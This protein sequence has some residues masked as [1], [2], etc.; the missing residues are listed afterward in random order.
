[1][2]EDINFKLE[3]PLGLLIGLGFVVLNAYFGYVIGIPLLAFSSD[4]ERYIVQDAVAPF[5]EEIVFRSFLPF[6]LAVLGIPLLINGI[7]NVVAFPIF[8]YVAY[9]A[10]FAAA[11]SLFIGAGI[12]ALAAF[13]ATYYNSEPDELQIPIAAIIAHV[14]INTWL[15]IKELGLVVIGGV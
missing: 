14:I 15:G 9:G 12:F 11:S 3:I 7:I 13:L 10:S 2:I 5:G 6:A 1:M 8:H 4:A